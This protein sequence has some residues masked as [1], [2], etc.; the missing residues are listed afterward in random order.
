MFGTQGESKKMTNPVYNDELWRRFSLHTIEDATN[1]SLE[2]D[3]PALFSNK[4]CDYF[5]EWVVSVGGDPYTDNNPRFWDCLV[6]NRELMQ[7]LLALSDET[8]PLRVAVDNAEKGPWRAA[9]ADAFV[10]VLDSRALMKSL[11]S[12]EEY[13]LYAYREVLL[14]LK[15]A[16]IRAAWFYRQFYDDDDEGL[17]VEEPVEERDPWFRYR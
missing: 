15:V 11:T 17:P 9:G 12:L 14:K 10:W 16:H 6:I 7:S 13:S 4:L 8:P 1:L 5:R 3:H 2:S